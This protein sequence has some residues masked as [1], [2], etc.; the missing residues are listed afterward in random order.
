MFFESL[1]GQFGI[2]KDSQ[3]LAIHWQTGPRFGR[4]FLHRIQR[5]RTGAIWLAEGR[6]I[7]AS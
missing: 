4:G 3:Y 5:G 1:W 6:M 7:W 2:S